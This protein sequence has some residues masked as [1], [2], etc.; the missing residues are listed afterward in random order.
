MDVQLL[1]QSW[2][3]NATSNKKAELRQQ[4]AY[5]INEMLLHDFE[6]LVQ[7]LY[8][9]DVSEQKLK[10]ELAG[11]PNQDAGEV[12]ADMMIKRQEEK[13]AVRHAFPPANNIA[14]DERW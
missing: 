4:L 11:N 14:E 13:L 6:K 2:D 10:T 9:V 8:A 5:L 3:A 12:I 7:L 1:I